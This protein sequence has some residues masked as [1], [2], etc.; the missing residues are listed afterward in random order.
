M[1][2]WLKKKQLHVIEQELSSSSGRLL[3]LFDV[4]EVRSSN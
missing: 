2:F 1:H 3:K 4:N